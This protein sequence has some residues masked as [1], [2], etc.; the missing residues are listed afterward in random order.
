MVEVCEGVRDHQKVGVRAG[1]SVSKTFT[2]G[3]II[4]PWF[5]T[6]FQPSTVVTTAPSDNQVRNQLWREIHASVNSSKIPLGGHLTALMWD[7]KPHKDILNRIEPDERQ[8]WEKNFAIGFST[9]PDTQ[10]EH[11]TKMQGWHNVWF[12]AVIEEACGILAPVWR[13]IIESLIIDEQCKVVAIG[14][15]TDPESD[16]A[17]ACY[18]S[19]PV[20][21]EGKEAYISDEGWYIVTIDARD[22]PNYVQNKRVIPGL[23]S[24]QYVEGIIKKY[25]EDG[26]GTR[27]RVKGLF[28]TFKEG[29]YY[30]RSL[31]KAR[32]DKRVGDFPC[33]IHA[34]VYSFN[35]FGDIWTATLFIQFIRGMVR[36]VGEYWDYEGLGLPA[37]SRVVSSKGWTYLGHFAGPDL[38]TS[39]AKNF[40]TGKTT[41]DVAAEY[42]KTLTAVI[43]HRKA[44]GI[45]AGRGIWPLMQVNERACPTFLKA[46]GGYGKKK[47]L[48]LCTNEQII[49]YDQEGKTWHRHFAD[50]F[51]HL[52]IAFRYM[53]IGGEYIGDISKIAAYHQTE[54]DQKPVDPM[55]WI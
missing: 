22:N 24:R 51:R 31:A 5:K 10:T 39:N 16:F 30:G 6:C 11:V 2:M 15:P 4:V 40:Q 19:D 7:V 29:T 44:D 32:K 34:P 38:E 41:I 48:R 55:D 49:Y 13:T 28:P 18:S 36:T 46:M 52:A 25:G 54:G 17:K 12:L 26:D 27:Y 1:H 33:D 45:E 23:A 43:P 50:A 42:G 14:N 53:E 8:Y 9:S 20:K 37:W 21:Q 47:N 3:R 35:D